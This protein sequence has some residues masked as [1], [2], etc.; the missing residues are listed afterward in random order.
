M[1]H[2][3]V[4]PLPIS[5]V[6]SY[7][8]S[9]KDLCVSQQAIRPEFNSIE[10]LYIWVHPEYRTYDNRTLKFYEFLFGEIANR[11]DCAVVEIPFYS[12]SSREGIS[13]SNC[14]DVDDR[15]MDFM[16]AHQKLRTANQ[17]A[18]GPRYVLREKLGFLEG[19]EQESIDWLKLTINVDFRNLAPV[20][21]I[22][23]NYG[24]Y[25][26]ARPESIRLFKHIVC[27]GQLPW[28][29]VWNQAKTCNLDLLGITIHHGL[30]EGITPDNL[31]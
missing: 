18:F 2:S 26:L 8:P 27:F 13:K 23:Q 4:D 14:A 22:A 24:N 31:K 28:V 29:C 9:L 19:R 21:Q 20:P 11:K 10:N 17:Q 15:F 7:E 12:D 1:I 16:Q 30:L 5:S 3:M 25:N 6:S